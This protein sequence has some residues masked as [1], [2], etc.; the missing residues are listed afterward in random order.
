MKQRNKVYREHGFAVEDRAP[1]DIGLLWAFNANA[2]S[3]VFW[4]ILHILATQGLLESVRKECDPFTLPPSPPNGSTP[5][6]ALDTQGIL[7]SCPILKACYF[8]SL[9]LNHEPTSLRY[10]LKDFTIQPPPSPAA[11]PYIA[12]AGSFITIPHS[13]NQYDPA[14]YLNPTVFDHTRFLHIDQ[15]TG[16]LVARQGSLMPWGGGLPI[17]KGR[18]FAER[19]VLLIV[20]SVLALWDFEPVEEGG[21][22]VPDMIKG[23]GVNMP[24]GDLRTRIRRRVR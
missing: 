14:K 15:E 19:E 13:I 7:R 20:A 11:A 3:L 5:V 17:C 18:V 2:N 6:L 16:V 9:R 4:I 1:L 8:E 22:K 12:K 24:K 23:T 10:V 21:W